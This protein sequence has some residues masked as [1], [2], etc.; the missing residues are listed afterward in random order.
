MITICNMNRLR[1]SKVEEYNLTNELQAL[2]FD[3]DFAHYTAPYRWRGRRQE[4]RMEF[5]NW[6]LSHNFTTTRQIYEVLGHQCFPFFVYAETGFLQ[7]TFGKALCNATG[8]SRIEPVY[9]SIYG[10]CYKVILEELDM[11]PPNDISVTDADGSDRKWMSAVAV[12]TVLHAI[13]PNYTRYD[14]TTER[15]FAHKIHT[16]QYRQ[17]SSTRFPVRHATVNP[18]R[19][20]RN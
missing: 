20:S 13:R 2:F 17:S 16:K 18:Q 14:Q 1:K 3:S 4:A 12:P 7:R 15:C 9:T 6:R 8:S 5:A 19:Y 10:I 11:T